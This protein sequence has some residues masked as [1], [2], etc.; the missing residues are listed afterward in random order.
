MGSI[1]Y[2]RI[3]RTI[4]SESYNTRESFLT[5][6]ENIDYNKPGQIRYTA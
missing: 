4:N 5:G 2:D 6:I 3:Y 1:I